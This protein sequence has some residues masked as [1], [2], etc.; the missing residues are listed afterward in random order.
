MDKWIISKLNTLVKEV[1]SKLDNY[2]ITGAA[3]EIE[4]FT[5]ELSIGM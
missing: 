1:D 5:D 3:I 4:E 2:D